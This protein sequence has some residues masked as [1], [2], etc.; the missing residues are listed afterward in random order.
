MATAASNSLASA[1]AATRWAAARR[2]GSARI[3]TMSLAALPARSQVSATPRRCGRP[4]SGGL[5]WDDSTLD[6]FIADPHALVPRSRM[7]FAGI[8]GMD[9]QGCAHR[10]AA[11][12]FRRP[13]RSAA[14]GANGH[15]RGVWPRSHDSRHSGRPGIRRLS[16][17]RVHH[18][19]P[20]GRCRQGHPL[21]CGM[22]GR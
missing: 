3:S 7:S 12:L 1:S 13:R 9:D 20:D 11:R 18:L 10:L 16:G 8:K 17:G 22:A 14:G 15:A 2:I 21:N 4:V 6:A 19:S 5:V